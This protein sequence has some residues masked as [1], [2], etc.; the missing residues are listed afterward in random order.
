MY[1]INEVLL[2]FAV[3]R[4]MIFVSVSLKYMSFIA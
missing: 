1:Y 4:G 3:C 2:V